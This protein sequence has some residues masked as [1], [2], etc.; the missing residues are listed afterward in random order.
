MEPIHC[1]FDGVEGIM[2]PKPSKAKQ[3]TALFKL[4]GG[5]LY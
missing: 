5:N 2:I 1:I 4:Q 3:L